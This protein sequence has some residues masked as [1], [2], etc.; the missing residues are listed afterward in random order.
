MLNVSIK[1]SRLSRLTLVGITALFLATSV[2]AQ[3]G[4]FKGK[5]RNQGGKGIPNAEIEARQ[6]GKVVKSAR[7]NN[8][9]DF[10]L[11]GL[12]SGKY[13]L[14]FDA[15]GYAT[16]V[17]F[18]VEVGDKVRELGERLMLA[19]D[20]GNIVF[21]RGSV[22]FKEGSSVTG[23]KVDLL[24][25]NSDGSTKRVESAY[26]DIRGDFAFRRPPGAGTYRV[27]AKLKSVTGSKDIVVDNAAIYRTAITL[28][29]SRNDR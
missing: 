20:Q 18:N 28:D 11:S 24:L 27:T 15:D 4:G 17:L 12:R 5:I 13:N 8:K 23:A 10:V 1:F 19:P 9:G 21:I 29:L 25:V 3:S 6:D 16:G 26:T 7:A 2:F 14:S 22:F